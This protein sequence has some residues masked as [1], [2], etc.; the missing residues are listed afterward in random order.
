VPPDP[1]STCR[2]N[3]PPL[4]SGQVSFDDDAPQTLEQYS[5]DVAAF[6]MRAAEPHL[7]FLEVI[8]PVRP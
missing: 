4:Q 1:A 5:K 2:S 6:L 7:P 8:D 3:A